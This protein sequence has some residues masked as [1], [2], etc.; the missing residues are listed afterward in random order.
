MCYNVWSHLSVEVSIWMLGFRTSV[1]F[2]HMY[3]CNACI[4]AQVLMRGFACLWAP[5]WHMGWKSLGDDS[6]CL[7]SLSLPSKLSQGCSLKSDI[8]KSTV[9][10]Q[11]IVLQTWHSLTPFYIW[12]QDIKT[13]IPL[14]MQQT[15]YSQ[16]IT[17]TLKYD[18]QGHFWNSNYVVSNSVYIHKQDILSL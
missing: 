15:K 18:F 14:P 16:A 11:V 7:S 9:F 3:A 12:V 2:I 4:H 10:S 13:S 8:L 5:A 6:R 1:S 17:P